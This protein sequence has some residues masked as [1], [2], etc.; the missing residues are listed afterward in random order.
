MTHSPFWKANSS[1][2]SQEISYIS[3]NKK[4]DYHKS[5]MPAVCHY[6]KLIQSTPK[7]WISIWSCVISISHLHLDLPSGT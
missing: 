7:Q 2:A 4:V 3:E 5:Q 1:S 6:P